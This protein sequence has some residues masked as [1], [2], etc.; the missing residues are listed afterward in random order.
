M[1]EHI[2]RRTNL[3]SSY[4]EVGADRTL[5]RIATLLRSS[6]LRAKENEDEVYGERKAHGIRLDRCQGI[7]YSAVCQVVRDD[8]LTTAR[9]S[10]TSIAIGFHRTA[11]GSTHA[12]AEAPTLSAIQSSTSHIRPGTNI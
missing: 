11:C 9:R 5:Q 12:A 2:H 8:S 3:C 6:M 7:P 1:H 4:E 10:P